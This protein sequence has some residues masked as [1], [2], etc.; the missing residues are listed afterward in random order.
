MTLES[1]QVV[2]GI[3]AVE[4]T[5]MD[6]AHEEIP[7]PSS[8]LSLVTEGVFSMQDGHLQG[9]FADVIVQGS[10]GMAKEQG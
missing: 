6:E 2:K 8:I 9:P 3:D 5:G 4:S 7:H 1:G 10:A